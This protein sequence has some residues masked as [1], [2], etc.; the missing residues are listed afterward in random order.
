MNDHV[1]AILMEYTFFRYD[2]GSISGVLAMDYF[3]KTFATQ[4][5]SAGIPAL[6]SGQTSLVVS[7]LSAGTFFGIIPPPQPAPMRTSF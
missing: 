6:T 7:I 1:D 5:D 4:N 3:Q 2:T